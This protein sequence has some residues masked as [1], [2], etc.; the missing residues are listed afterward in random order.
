[1]GGIRN[2]AFEI[3]LG[4][5]MY[6]PSSIKIGSGIQN[7]IG[8]YTYRHKQEAKLIILLSFFKIWNVG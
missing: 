1:M 3:E 7:L 5:M 2:Y 6:M 4:A 8:G